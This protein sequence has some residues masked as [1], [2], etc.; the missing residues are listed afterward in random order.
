MKSVVS[1]PPGR[2]A[3][4]SQRA[5]SHKSVFIAGS[6]EMGTCADWQSDLIAKFPEGITF[7]NP[8]R[9]EW[10]PSWE[11]SI[12]CPE[13]KEQVDWELDN[14]VVADIIFMYFDP[15]TK[16]PIS[17]LELGLFADSGKMI[18][19]CPDGFW[20]KGNVEVICDRF[21]IHLH[22]NL[23]DAITELKSRLW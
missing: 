19:C 13:F 20:R 23:E 8:R 2:S 15:S 16:A 17:L 18:V 6:I 14:L 3:V 22:Q 7:L 5:R 11:Q 4:Y 9:D 12:K 10:D 21:R 1:K